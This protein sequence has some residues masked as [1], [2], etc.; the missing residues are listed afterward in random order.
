MTPRA[1]KPSAPAPRVAVVA[2]ATGR[3]GR[4]LAQAFAREGCALALLSRTL[5]TPPP[6]VAAL[7]APRVL[8]LGCDLRSAPSV[9]AAAQAVRDALG[10]ADVVVNAA[11]ISR[12][13]PVN[14]LDPEDWADVIATNL[15]GA[16]A[17]TREFAPL[18]AARGGGHIMHLGSIRGFAGAPGGS[19]YC[20]SK[21]GLAGLVRAAASELGPENIRV[22]LL[23]PGLIDSA[24]SGG[25]SERAREETLRAHCLGRTADLAEV[26]AFAVFLATT[27]N[28][29]GQTFNLDSR[30]F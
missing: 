26:C 1:K 8:P 9:R 30:F 22:N 7:P 5:Q 4:A 18:L 21:A 29:S 14:S 12:N 11:G 20:A 28:I 24:L 6:W 10:G 25:L 16:R 17:L 27:Q 15:S 3:I 13:G 19:A 2:G 23:L